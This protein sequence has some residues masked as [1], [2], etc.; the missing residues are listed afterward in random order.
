MVTNLRS[1][2]YYI[3]AIIITIA[4]LLSFTAQASAT[5]FIYGDVDGNG[6][7]MMYDAVILQKNIVKLNDLTMTEELRGDVNI[8][9]SITMKDVVYI[10]RY[11][12]KLIDKFPVSN[13][14]EIDS[15]GYING[16]F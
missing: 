1:L 14:F 10:Q 9:K 13:D 11:I 3:T 12:A 7:V 5:A 16:I 6:E 2:K 15:D 8:D 4:M